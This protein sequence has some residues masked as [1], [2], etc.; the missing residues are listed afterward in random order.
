MDIVV[1]SVVIA[2]SGRDKGGCFVVTQ[3]LENGYLLI[4][5][6]KRRRIEHP[7]RKNIIHV[8]ATATVMPEL[9]SNRQIRKFL[10]QGGQ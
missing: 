8:Q 9:S 10:L 1:G 7:K 5:D 6:G 4:C 2:K 3:I